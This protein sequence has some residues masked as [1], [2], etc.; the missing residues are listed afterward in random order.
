MKSSCI[1]ALLATGLSLCACASPYGA[2]DISASQIDPATL[3]ITGRA[4]AHTGSETIQRYVL[5]RAAEET[6]KRGF[7]LFLMVPSLDNATTASPSHTAAIA[8]G[9]GGETMLVMMFHGEKP[10][11]APAN[12]YRASDVLPFSALYTDQQ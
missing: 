2:G 12:L 1:A 5:M 11:N 6:T 8:S 7:N 9:N 3:Q 4:N 10:S